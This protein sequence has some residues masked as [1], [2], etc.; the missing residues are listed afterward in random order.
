MLIMP[1]P[2]PPKTQ[3]SHMPA[4]GVMPASGFRLSCMQLTEPQVTAVVT[5]AKGRTGRG[6]EP[7]LL[8]FQVSQLLIDRQSGRAGHVDLLH[9]RPSVVPSTSIC[10]V[11]PSIGRA[12]LRGQRRVGLQRVP[13]D[14]QP[15]MATN[16][17]IITP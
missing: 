9:G 10:T 2:L 15:I 4:I 7:Q 6:A 8:A 14:A 1:T 16:M 5:A 3:L 12:P 13:I 11:C 17:T